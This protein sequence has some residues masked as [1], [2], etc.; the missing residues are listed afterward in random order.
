MKTLH[1]A[2]KLISILRACPSIGQ[3]ALL[4]CLPCVIVSCVPQAGKPTADYKT[5]DSNSTPQYQTEKAQPVGELE[6]ILQTMDIT[7][8]V[9][10]LLIIDLYDSHGEAI[11]HV[12]P[13]MEDWLSVLEPG[14]VVLYGGN[15]DTLSQVRELTSRLQDST[16]VPLL[17]AVDHEGGIVNRF[18]DSGNISLTEIPAASQIG[19]VGDPDLTY[20]IGA[21][22]ARELSALGI[23]MNFA[24]VADIA[25]SAH[26]VIGSRS[27]GSDPVGVAQ[28]VASL[29]L[30]MQDYGVS[31]VIKHFPGHGAAVGDTHSGTVVLNRT[32]EELE[33]D[34]FVPFVHG[35]NAGADGIMIA[36][37]VVPSITT[38]LT[39]ST[40]S[41]EI[42]TGILRHAL[43]FRN[44][45]ITDSLTMG[46]AEEPK[47]GDKAV[48]S[49]LAGSDMLLRP[50]NPELVKKMLLDA[51]QK[52][53]LRESRID[54]SVRRIL[55]VKL[56][57]R[58]SADKLITQEAALE[59]LND[60]SH[61]KV[62]DTVR[63]SRR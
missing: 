29:V 51:V 62:V 63:S 36:H 32:R 15:I 6:H 7:Q 35:I 14:G 24:P 18:D 46:S 45:A 20:Q 59:V 1:G 53:K 44:I 55:E 38:D 8:K 11:R 31:A 22:M 4:A 37:L 49:I 41:W 19:N 48:E 33:S 17:I 23:N 16:R 34:E 13:A 56:L 52:G 26:S 27:Y 50:S 28:M 3:L 42:M 58:P 30:G 12:N 47:N 25:I 40:L 61:R 5:N 2:R 10:Q 60:P 43:G 54:E 57:R 9:G 21:I 39:P